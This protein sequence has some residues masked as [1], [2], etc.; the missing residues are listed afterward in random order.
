MGRI[1]LLVRKDLLRVTRSPV[2]LLVMLAFPVVFSLLIGLTF[3]TGDSAPPKVSLLVEDRDQSFLS[4]FLVGAFES[5]QAG[6]HFETRTVGPEGRE[7]IEKGEASALLRIPEGFTEDLLRGEPLTLELVRNPAQSIMPEIA[8]QATVILAELLD[9]GSRLLR[10]P[11]DRLEPYMDMEETEMTSAQVAELSVAFHEAFQGAEKF[12][13]PPV[14]VLDS[15]QL[16]EADDE[17]EAA[18]T[19]SGSF[20]V[21]LWMLPAVSVYALFMIGDMSMRDIL[22]EGTMGTLR[23][24]L[25]GPISARTLVLGKAAYTCLITL[26]SLVILTLIGWIALDDPV[27]LPAFATLSLA[28][29]VAVTGFGAFIYSL[30]RSAGQG[31]TVSSILLLAFGFTGGAFLPLSSLPTFIQQIA[32]ISPFYWATTGFQELLRPGTGLQEVLFNTAVLVCIG[33]VLFL[34]GAMLLDRRIRRGGAA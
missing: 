9:A 25:S 12:V 11:L 3:G 27:S 10:E 17:E 4:S 32:P 28:V 8:E 20:S 5:E 13:F 29:I 15:V 19:S 18:P 34:V 7:M 2:G 31:A 30:A 1:A 21:F 14:I 22:T 24:Q 26:I 16:E 6:E 33:V 23:R